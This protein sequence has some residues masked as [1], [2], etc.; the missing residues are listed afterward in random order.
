MTHFDVTEHRN[1]WAK[2]TLAPQ[3]FV[4]YFSGIFFP[5]ISIAYVSLVIARGTLID[6]LAMA[7][8]LFC[9]GAGLVALFYVRGLRSAIITGVD[10]QTDGVEFIRGNGRK[11]RMSWSQ[12]DFYLDLWEVIRP[13]P[14]LTNLVEKYPVYRG[15]LESGADLGAISG[16]AFTAIL[17]GAKQGGLAINPRQHL[18][19]DGTGESVIHEIRGR[20]WG[21]VPFRDPAA[22]A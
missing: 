13:E 9:A 8:A 2:R 5:I 20:A 18:A 14:T 17:T 7:I 15:S 4:G 3:T 10:V 22:K 6:W 12:P 1:R 11:L 21:A 16:D 19:S